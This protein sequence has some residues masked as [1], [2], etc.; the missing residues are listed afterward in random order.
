MGTPSREEQQKRLLA[1]LTTRPANA[2]ELTKRLDISQ[3]T[4]SRL[5][6]S[7]GNGVLTIG[8]ARATMYARPRDIRGLGHEFPVFDIDTAGNARIAGTLY[9]VWETSYFWEPAQ[10]PPALYRDLPWFIRD[11]CP[12]GFV[13]RA[14]AHRQHSELNLP[15]RLNDWNSDQ[16]LIALSCRGEDCMGNLILGHESLSRYFDAPAKRIID[17]PERA[18]DYPNLAEQAIEGDPAGSSAGGEQPK[19]TTIINDGDIHHVLVKFSPPMDTEEGQRWADLLICESVAS[20]IIAAAGIRA[21]D[22]VI[23]RA[24]GRTFLE[25]RRFDR[26][27]LS[28]RLPMHSLGAVDNEFVGQ[29]TGW[30]TMANRLEKG[31]LISPAD[32][33]AI[34]WLSLFG[35]LIGNTDQHFGNISLIPADLSHRRFALAPA[36]DMLPMLYRPKEGRGTKPEF[37]PRRT[38][39]ALEWASAVEAALRFWDRVTHDGRISEEFRRICSGNIDTVQALQEGPRLIRP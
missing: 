4:L 21:A 26:V 38:P 30:V 2:A 18:S 34:R 37:A 15:P 36:Y 9:P 24:G 6:A 11:L 27:G 29:G 5:L 3:A 19:F 17:L 35:D 33:S 1:I 7:L 32:G 28:G 39:A 22:S 12:E 25:V 10:G 14:F 13:G 16:M 23:L 31:K 8:N 20:E